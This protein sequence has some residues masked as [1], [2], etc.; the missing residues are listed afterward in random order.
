MFSVAVIPP[1]G[2]AANTLFRTALFPH[3]HNRHHL[4]LVD[5]AHGTVLS[6]L[7]VRSCHTDQP[8]SGH[9]L[10]LRVQERKGKL[11]MCQSWDSE[12]LGMRTCALCTEGHRRNTGSTA[13]GKNEG[14]GNRR[15]H[16]QNSSKALAQTV[17]THRSMIIKNLRI[18]TLLALVAQGLSF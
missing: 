8:G 15:K 10:C 13:K 1:T 7:T 2:G 6:S 3:V 16:F 18:H 14:W 9:L 4:F 5:T 11:R 12:S 17:K